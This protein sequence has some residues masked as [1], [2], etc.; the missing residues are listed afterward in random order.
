MR[1]SGR[2]ATPKEIKGR[3]PRQLFSEC[4]ETR[5]R[6]AHRA[7]LDPSIPLADLAAGL[8]EFV[9]TLIWKRNALPPLSIDTP[10]SSLSIPEGG[11]KIR[12]L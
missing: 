11:L 5:N 7:A 12:V 10:A 6:I 2:L 1:F 9:L 8:R 3:T 4:V